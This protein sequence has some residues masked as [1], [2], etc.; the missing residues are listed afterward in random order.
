MKYNK[1][2]LAFYFVITTGM[3]TDHKNGNEAI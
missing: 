3:N 1:R 2:V